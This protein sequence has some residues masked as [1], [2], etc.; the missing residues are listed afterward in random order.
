MTSHSID[1]ALN[2]IRILQNQIGPSDDCLRELSTFSFDLEKVSNEVRNMRP[3]LFFK[4][5]DLTEKHYEGR[6]PGYHQVSKEEHRYESNKLVL[7]TIQ[8]LLKDE[9]LTAEWI[10]NNLDEFTRSCMST[11]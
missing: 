3:E 4:I 5:Q 2:R 6:G 11:G 9:G 8:S 1:K 10:I 7:S